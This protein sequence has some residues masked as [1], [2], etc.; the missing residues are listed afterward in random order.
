MQARDMAAAV[1][2]TAEGALALCLTAT[3]VLFLLPAAVHAA[4]RL[5]AACNLDAPGTRIAARVPSF[6][7]V[8]F[9]LTS[10]SSSPPAPPLVV[11]R[12][13]AGPPWSWTSGSPSPPRPLVPARAPSPERREPRSRRVSVLG[14]GAY[15]PDRDRG[16]PAF[17]GRRR[18]SGAPGERLFPSRTGRVSERARAEAGTPIATYR[19][20]GDD[21][22]VAR[23]PGDS[24]PGAER[25]EAGPCH[26]QTHTVLPGETL[27]SIAGAA[28]GT[29]DAQRIARYWPRIH[30]DNRAL[31]G[32]TPDLIRPGWVLRLPPECD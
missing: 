7:G 11:P 28:L 29:T 13:G 16:H 1:F 2:L 26:R 18:A 30:R 25:P 15:T 19:G 24:G 27:W 22:E 14:A 12:Q 23:E 20:R 10:S 31:I 5:A 4:R 21:P 32:S 8:A 6:I 17:H 9:A 3:A